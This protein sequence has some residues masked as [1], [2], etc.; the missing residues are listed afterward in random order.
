MALAISALLAAL[1]AENGQ[2]YVYACFFLISVRALRM[3]STHR[4]HLS[5]PDSHGSGGTEQTE[6]R[7]RPAS[8]SFC[9]AR[10]CLLW[11]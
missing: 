8:A 1:K 7:M 6:A 4:A 5:G 2:D 9:D 10:H 11:I 3:A